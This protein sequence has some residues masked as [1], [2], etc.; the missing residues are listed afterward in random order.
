MGAVCT[1][2]GVEEGRL[3]QRRRRRNEARAAALY[4]CRKWA[5]MTLEELGERFGGVSRQAVGRL[6]A[7]LAREVLRDTELGERVGRCEAELGL[8]K[9]DNVDI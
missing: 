1:V 9:V 4:L 6:E 3:R 5:G 7:R 8:G 2:F